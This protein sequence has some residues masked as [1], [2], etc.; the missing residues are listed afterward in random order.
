M[1]PEMSSLTK[2]LA[3]VLAPLGKR[4][5]RR[6]IK[7][8]LDWLAVDLGGLEEARFRVLGAELRIDKAPKPRG[9]PRRM[10]RVLIADYTNRR[11]LDVTVDARGRVL[12]G[13]AFRGFQPAFYVEEIAE[14]RDIA[15]QDTRVSGVVKRRGAFPVPFA[16]GHGAEPGPRAVGLHYLMAT[17]G[18][19]AAPLATVVVD[20]YEQAVTSFEDERRGQGTPRPS[21]RMPGRSRGRLR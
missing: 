5:E 20:L 21:G 13:T 6:A 18:G 19:A 7:A 3:P 4:D 14:A 2:R 1:R 8:A 17:R 15:E 11:N 12:K 16:P 9:V 10:V